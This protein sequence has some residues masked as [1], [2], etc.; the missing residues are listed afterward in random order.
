MKEV[1]FRKGTMLKRPIEMSKEELLNW[2]KQGEKEAREFLFSIKQPLVY[3]NSEGFLVA[4]KFDGSV[5]KIK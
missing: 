4:E 2:Q 3:Y 1:K 5:E